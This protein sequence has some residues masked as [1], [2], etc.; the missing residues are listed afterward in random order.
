MCRIAV[1]PVDG[2][3][4]LDEGDE[5]EIDDAGDDNVQLCAR[6]DAVAIHAFGSNLV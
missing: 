4:R 1:D 3:G 6:E 2:T 5:E